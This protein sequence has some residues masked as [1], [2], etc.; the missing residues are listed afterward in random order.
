[1]L[2]LSKSLWITDIF[3]RLFT[4]YKIDLYFSANKKHFIFSI[5]TFVIQSNINRYCS[6]ITAQNSLRYFFV[7]DRDFGAIANCTCF[8]KKA[9]SQYLFVNELCLR[10]P[11]WFISNL[12]TEIKQVSVLSYRQ[13]KRVIVC[14]SGHSRQYTLLLYYY[15]AVMV[16]LFEMALLFSILLLIYTFFIAFS[17][18][19][20]YSNVFRKSKG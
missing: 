14:A 13:R 6:E 10:P 20:N 11:K 15:L 3:A 7:V 4:L 9:V 19:W 16:M 18:C 2:F 5:D 17:M 12:F 1:M 8:S